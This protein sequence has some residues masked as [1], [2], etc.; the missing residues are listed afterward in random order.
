MRCGVKRCGIKNDVAVVIAVV[1]TDVRVSGGGGVG[2]WGELVA[3][4][5]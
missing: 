3:M 4:T 2:I 5:V 1:W